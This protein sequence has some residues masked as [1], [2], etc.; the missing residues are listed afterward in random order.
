MY[1]IGHNFLFEVPAVEQV[2]FARTVAHAGQKQILAQLLVC[3]TTL[4]TSYI[5]SMP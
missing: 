5:E 1:L 3:T 4:A 2:A